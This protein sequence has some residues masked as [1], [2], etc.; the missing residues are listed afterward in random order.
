MLVWNE[1]WPDVGTGREEPLKQRSVSFRT[2]LEQD[3]S[4]ALKY[5]YCS[6]QSG[7]GG[8]VLPNTRL[9]RKGWGGSCWDLDAAR[10]CLDFIPRALEIQLIKFNNTSFL[11]LPPH[12]QHC[13]NNLSASCSFLFTFKYQRVRCRPIETSV[14]DAG[15]IFSPFHGHVHS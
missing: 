8:C 10:K 2:W 6:R 13:D 1:S 5:Q 15:W 7:V 9:E 14:F 4:E 11:D 3:T 12:P